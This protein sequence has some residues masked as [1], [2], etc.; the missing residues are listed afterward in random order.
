M[1]SL[2][3]LIAFALIVFTS[4]SFAQSKIG[5]VDSDTIMD[6]LTEAQDA[7]QQ[8]D[9]YIQEWQSD[10]KKMENEWKSKYDDYEKRKL[11]MSDQNRAE[12]ESELI[13]LEQSIGEFREKKFGTNGELFQKQ[14]ELMKPVQNKVF[15]VIKEVAVSEDLDFVL[16]RSGGVLLLY[17]KEKYDIT[18]LVIEKLKRAQ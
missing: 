18:N 5:Y 3:Y 17:A 6:Q 8:L 10:L 7:R 16:D 13:K 2:K 1:K 12:L 15:T 11:I 14:D 9:T 4:S